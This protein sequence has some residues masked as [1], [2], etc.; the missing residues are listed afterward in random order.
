VVPRNVRLNL[1]PQRIILNIQLVRQLRV[2]PGAS[3]TGRQT[4]REH[5]VDAGGSDELSIK[6]ELVRRV[7][8]RYTRSYRAGGRVVVP[9]NS[10]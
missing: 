9:L 3:R 2:A 7:V 1:Q 8:A 5:V 10:Y 6:G 4:E